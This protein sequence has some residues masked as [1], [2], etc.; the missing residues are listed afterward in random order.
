MTRRKGIL[1]KGTAEAKDK[2]RASLQKRFL[3]GCRRT[4]CDE[5]VEKSPQSG[6]SVAPVILQLDLPPAEASW[7]R[8]FSHLSLCGIYGCTK[9][10]EEG[11]HISQ[12]L[13]LSELLS[14]Q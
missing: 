2:R 12:R 11:Y 1:D 10:P 3:R 4:K 8:H 6:P 5:D 9:V 7:L 14:T 13:A